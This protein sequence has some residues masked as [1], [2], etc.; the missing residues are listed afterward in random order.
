MN[1][2]RMKKAQERKEKALDMWYK[3]MTP[4]AKFLDDQAEKKRKK[5]ATKGESMTFDDVA[6]I[7]AKVLI[8]EMVKYGKTKKTFVVCEWQHDDYYHNIVDEVKSETKNKYITQ[9]AY[10]N[11]YGVENNVAMANAIAKALEQHGL[12]IE[13]TNE[14]EEYMWDCNNYQFTMRAYIK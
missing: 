3:A 7:Y 12:R 1:I 9:W 11:M 8:K 13:I 5:I 2:E 4:V 6:K 14:E 10:N